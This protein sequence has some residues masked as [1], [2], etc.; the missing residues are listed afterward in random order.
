MKKVL[1]TLLI[2]VLTTTCVVAKGDI[3]VSLGK[4]LNSEQRT[5][6]LKL[7]GADESAKIIEVTNQEE[8]KYLG[9]HV[10]SKL[11]GTRA[12][13][14]SYVEI[15]GNGEGIQAE[16][17]NVSWVTKDMVINALATAGVKD[18][19]VKVAAPF[20]VSGTAALTGIIKGFE[21]ATGSTISEEEKEI[22]NEEIAKTGELGQDI[23]K[24]EATE[25]IKKVKEEVVENKV[26]DPE[27]IKQIVQETA[28]EINITLTDAQIQKIIELMQKIANLDLDLG[29]IKAQL[30]NISDKLG[31]I[32]ENSEEVK[33]LLG[34]IVEF[35]RRL[36]EKISSK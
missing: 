20:E 34:K 4:D 35:F 13:S 33:S 10:D 26:K 8:R 24:D 25:L 36:L 15:L 27:E 28:K 21:D 9:K 12:I 14:S 32:G 5:Q 30:K 22:A 16:V 3:V 1:L 29:Q 7:L 11:L 17:Y 19:K 6:M 31:K 23:G 2:I 18:A